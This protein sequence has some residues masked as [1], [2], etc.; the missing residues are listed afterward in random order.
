MSETPR[1]EAIC[2]THHARDMAVSETS[3]RYEAGDTSYY[4][5]GERVT[6]DEYERRWN[7]LQQLRQARS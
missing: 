3:W 6:Q 1:F 7:E 4:I 2:E 5:D